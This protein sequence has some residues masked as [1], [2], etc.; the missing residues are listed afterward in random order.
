MVFYTH[1]IA[2]F[3]VNCKLIVSIIDMKILKEIHNNVYEAMNDQV[4]NH[5]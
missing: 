3:K 4:V 2:L 5:P 1:H